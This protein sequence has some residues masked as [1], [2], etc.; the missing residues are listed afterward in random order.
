MM[1]DLCG[2]KNKKGDEWIESPVALKIFS[3]EVYC[4]IPSGFTARAIISG[5]LF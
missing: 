4:A 3:S 2:H 1:I 5:F